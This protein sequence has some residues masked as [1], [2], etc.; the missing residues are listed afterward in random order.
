MPLAGDEAAQAIA[1]ANRRLAGAGVPGSIVLIA[2][3]I[4]ASQRDGLK[5][6][7]EAGGADVHVLAMAAGPEVIPPPG[8]PPAPAL[9][10]DGM[11][12]AARAAGGS[13]TLVSIDDSDVRSLAAN[14]ERSF[15]NAP[16]QEGSRWRDAGWYLLIP[17]ALILL[18][19]FRPGGAVPIART[20]L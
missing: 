4:D 17:L 6:E 9:D 5:A 1:L 20:G 19:F 2:D 18:L 14:I 8:S 10:K 12:A 13:L 11:R 16:L 3:N 15:A 7:N